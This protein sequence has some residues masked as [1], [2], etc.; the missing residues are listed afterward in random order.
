MERKY[1]LTFSKYRAEECE[2]PPPMTKQ[3][4]AQ[5]AEMSARQVAKSL[6]ILSMIA[7]AVVIED[8]SEDGK[9]GLFDTVELF[10]EDENEEIQRQMEFE[11]MQMDMAAESGY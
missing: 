3:S 9:A 2:Q 8:N 6:D 7:S 11:Q 4:G 1:S 10:M 5:I